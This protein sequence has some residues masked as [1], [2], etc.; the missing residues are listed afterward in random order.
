MI[1]FQDPLDNCG[2]PGDQ[3]FLLVYVRTPPVSAV[4]P[5]DSRCRSHLHRQYSLSCRHHLQSKSIQVLV[6][7]S[8]C[9]IFK[10]S[11]CKTFEDR[12]GF[13]YWKPISKW[14][15]VPTT[16]V[17][18]HAPV[19]NQYGLAYKHGAGMI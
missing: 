8:W 14:A 18:R 12:V 13:I 1:I 5:Q 9:N 17:W 6:Y 11:H 16:A 4:Q 7:L 10:S 15:L 19:Q 2:T 3:L